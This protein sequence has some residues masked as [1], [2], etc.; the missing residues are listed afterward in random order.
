MHCAS[1]V[2]VIEEAARKTHGVQSAAVNL[3]LE[4][5]QL[6][7]DPDTFQ[8]PEFEASLRAQGYRAAV[9]R[10]I[11]RVSGLDPAGLAAVEKKLRAVP[12]VTAATANYATGTVAVEVLFDG[13]VEDLLRKEGLDPQPEEV[14]TSDHEF[15]RLA[16]RT[17]V[18]LVLATL[19]MAL[20]MAGRA[21]QWL[22]VL[23]AAP[24]QVWGGFDFHAGFFRSLVHRR[25]D[26]NT[27]VSIGTTAAFL[28]GLLGGSP[29]YDTAAMIIAIVLLGRLLEQRAK[30]GT[31]RAIEALLEL[32]P[33]EPVKPGDERTLKPG[34]R[35]P[36]DGVVQEGTAAVDESMLTGESVPVDKKPGDRVMG[37]TLNGLGSLRVRFDRT[38]DD[39]VLSGIVRSVRAAQATKPEA[40][41]VADLWAG[42]FVPIVLALAL[43]TLLFWLTFDRS[44]AL[45]STLAVLLVACPCAFGLATPA[46]IMVATGRAARKGMLFKDATA[47]EGMARLDRLVF[48]KTGTLT[49]G[50]PA[51]REVRSAPGFTR[52][53]VL[54]WASAVENKSE[55]PLGRA[56]AREAPQAPEAQEFEARPGLGAVARVEGHTV[57]VGSRALFKDEGIEFSPLQ[58]DL[59]KA[60]AAGETPVLLAID[61]RLAGLLTLADPPRPDAAP[62]V[63]ELK[64]LGLRVGMLTGDDAAAARQV[65]RTL[66]IE[67]VEAQVLPSQKAAK[68]RELQARERVGMVGDGIND[69]PALTQA[70]VGIAVRQ[71][72]DIALESADLVLM[73]SDLGRLPAAVRLARATR[74][75]IHQNFV[76]AVGYNAILIPI[77]AGVLRPW[78]G[79]LHPMLAAAAMALSSISVVLNS[80]R[81]GRA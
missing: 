28:A 74:R 45:G 71:G 48:D 64:S 31:R 42:R 4:H 68:I 35:F 79:S 14:S 51:L 70:D 29:Y 34:E 13:G 72:S 27:L 59:E 5:A 52:E 63:T 26:M 54:R 30:R 49:L 21:P 44:Q 19:V 66:G 46:A 25:A 38:G 40:Q 24:V 41:R 75:V 12:G 7:I 8:A 76:W 2:Q 17:G 20:T 53:E 57:F 55:H 56:I 77:A 36:A 6:D 78:G 65:A 60:A 73:K 61:G 47:L 16:I 9:R 69:A 3:A 80:L 18:S 23:L 33:Q 37:G 15:R 11:Y 43:G 10:R 32:S 39:T 1:C 58:E 22:L 62:V 81:L 67:D 50:R